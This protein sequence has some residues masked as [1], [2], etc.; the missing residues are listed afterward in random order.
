M[1][2]ISQEDLDILANAAGCAFSNYGTEEDETGKVTHTRKDELARV[3]A[4]LDY[5][6]SDLCETFMAK[7]K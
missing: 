3:M 5:E 2:T 6:W 1:R 4:N 7:E